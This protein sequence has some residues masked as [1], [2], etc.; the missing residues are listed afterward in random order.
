M[1]KLRNICRNDPNYFCNIC[2]EYTFKNCR[3]GVSEFITQVYFDYF[4]FAL[5]IRDKYWIPHMV[6]KTC[7]ESLRLWA[8]KKR[9]HFKYQTPMIWREPYNHQDD[10]YFCVVDINGI[11]KNNRSKW[12]YPNLLSV[13]R[14]VLFSGDAPVPQASSSVQNDHDIEKQNYSSS[15][16][17][18]TSDSY[19]DFTSE[20]QLFNQEDLNALIRDLGLSKKTSEILASRLKQRNLLTP[21]TRISYYRNREAELLSFFSKD[22][23]FAFC[24]DV[25]GLL[26]AM[27]VQKYDPNEWRLFIDSSKRSLK[28]VLMH[29]GNKLGSIPIAHSTTVKEEYATV[30]SVMDR[31]KYN[32]QKWLISVDLKMVNFLLGQQGGYTKYPCF[33]CLWDS[34]ARS[35][36][37]IR[38]DWP[39]RQSMVPGQLNVINEPLVPT[40][41][42]ILPPLHIKLGLMKQ[43]VKALNKGGDCYK[44]ISKKFF[45][46]SQEKI[47]NGIFDG[48]QIRR[49]IK[50]EN[51]I[52]YM[53]DIEK[54]AWNEFVWTAQNFL[55]N[56]KEE[57]YAEHIELMLLHFQQLGCNMSIKVHFLH[58]HLDRFPENLGDLSEEQGERFHQDIRT[59]EERY[60]GHW[61]AHMMADYCWSIKNSPR[62]PNQA[63]KSYKRKFFDM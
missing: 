27:G 9:P 57:S 19:P 46:L 12:S 40:D 15:D 33:I 34:R 26:K 24:S 39:S 20:P 52:S 55:G 51:F 30:A 23:D 16:E 54:N 44:Y 58:S 7:V 1:S 14:P 31:I 2:G 53:T 45:N 10:C 38:K 36:H 35:E 56:K 25:P 48:P 41:R 61:N 32:E 42:I 60:Q 5:D 49:L 13:T 37:W 21:E 50:D 28:C 17:S 47:K 59:M 29:N 3:L 22:D 62:E 43:F 63:R 6:C 11:N 4:G 18:R 8:N